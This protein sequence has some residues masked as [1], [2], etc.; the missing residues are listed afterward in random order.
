M[1]ILYVTPAFPYP[2][3]SGF[4]RQYHFIR[5]LAGRHSIRLV[6]M[7]GADFE[8]EHVAAMAPLVAGVHPVHSTARSNGVRRKAAGR[9]RAWLD[10]AHGD[11]AARDLSAV[12][13]D[14]VHRDRFD[15]LFVS[16]KRTYPA[17]RAAAGIPVVADLCDATSVRLRGQMRHA[18]PARRL[19]LA[20]EYAHVRELERRFV[21]EAAHLLFASA[22]DRDALAPADEPE[23]ASVVPNGVDL[24]YWQ[25]S[26][27]ARGG[28]DIV[29]TGAMSYPPNED[30]A[31][32]LVESILPRVRRTVPTARLWIVGRD[33]RPRLVRA[34]RRQHGVTVTG[35]VA[36]VRPYL[37]RA[38]VLAAPL[39]FGAGIQNKLLE[40]LAMQVPVVA[41]PLAAAGLRTADG[42]SPPVQ[43]AADA[44]AFAAAL[45]ERLADVGRDPHGAGRAFVARHFAWR[46]TGAQLE[47]VLARVAAARDRAS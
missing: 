43:V 45:A 33:P 5:E 12:V 34:G 13:R 20:L 32:W 17:L 24:E 41:S 9:L 30:A 16:G 40:A 10:P 31:L 44:E 3:T 22:R 47:A 28:C 27:T 39:R 2:L 6:S 25:R 23:R 14:C 18:Q 29:L 4:L 11:A 7:V 26:S 38:T 21:R 42:Q 15:A 35:T 46:T 8:P 36:D 1:H 37:D 19:V